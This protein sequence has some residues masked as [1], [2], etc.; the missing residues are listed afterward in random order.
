MF[1]KSENLLSEETEKSM[2]ESTGILV[3]GKNDIMEIFRCQS[4]K[5]L[6]ILKYMHQVHDAVKIGKE[7]YTTDGML[8]RFFDDFQGKEVLI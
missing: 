5:A 7:Y 2:D 6:R 4:D 8:R 3:Y 1:I